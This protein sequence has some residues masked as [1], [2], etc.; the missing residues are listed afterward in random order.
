MN[1][2]PERSLAPSAMLE[3]EEKSTNRK[4]HS[5][6]HPG[7]LILDFHSLEL[8]KINFWFFYKELSLWYFVIAV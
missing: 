5:P 8:W 7:T 6:D 2:T 1:E 3:Y 4:E